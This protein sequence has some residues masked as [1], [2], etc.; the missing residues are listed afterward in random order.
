MR[1]RLRD[2][3]ET[4]EG[5]IFS[6]VDYHNE[7]GVRCLLRYVPDPGGERARGDTRYRK[8]GFDEAYGFI[9]RERPGYLSGGVMVVPHGDVYRLYQPHEGLMQIITTD[10]RVRQMVEALADVQVC[11]M[12]ITGSK[13]VGLG[14]ETSDVD[15]VVYG[16]SWYLAR[17]QLRKAIA[18]GRIEGIDEEGWKRIYAKRKPELAFDEFYAH[19]RRKGNRCLLDGVLTDLLYVR[20]WDQIGPKVPVGRDLG[21]ATVTARVTGADFAFD[22]PAIY[23]VE[24]PEVRRVLSF[25]HTYAGQALPGEVIEAR[26]RLEESSAGKALVVGTSRE[27]K[28]EWIR[29]LTLLGHH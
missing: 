11:D 20:D 19:E 14:A 18:D 28:G 23:E 22:S 4:K 13:L 27:P 21:M 8:M 12:G 26:G 1:A 10:R 7:D 24:H 25:T 5:W 2:F 15:F 29:S 9:G 17:E 16:D 6:V 3:I